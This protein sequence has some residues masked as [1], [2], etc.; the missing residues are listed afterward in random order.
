MMYFNGMNG[1]SSDYHKNRFLQEVYSKTQ[2]LRQPLT[3]IVSGYHQLPYILIA[4]D[5]EDSAKSVEINGKINVSPKFIVSPTYLGETFGE[6][7][8]PSTFDNEIQGR[9]FSFAYAQKKNL[10]VESEYL[11][12]KYIETRAEEHLDKVHEDLQRHENIK[13]GLIL[14]PHFQ[15]YPVSVDRFV[16]EIV[17]REFNV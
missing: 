9:F 4:P 13:T 11:T 6:V 14:G 3:G 1:F 7:F 10:K 5:D 2:I 8:D 16:N 15:Y 17:A 12:I